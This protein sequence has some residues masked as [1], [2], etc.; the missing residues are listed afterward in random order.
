MAGFFDTLFGGGAEKEA[1]DKDR[2]LYGDFQ[3]KGADFLKTGYDTSTGYLNQAVGAYDP[4]K[5]LAGKYG[6]GTDT[7]LNALGVNGPAGS[8]AAQSAFQTTPGYALSNAAGLDA[9]NQRRAL[10]GGFNA[11]QTD[12][13]AI[14]FGQNNLYQTQYAPWMA[15]LQGVN[16]NNLAATTGAAAGTAGAYGSL[17]DLSKAYAGDQTSLLSNYTSGM[18]N[19][20]NLQAAGEAAGAKN[21]MSG[22][23][24]LGS[25]LLTGGGSAGFSGTAAGKLFGI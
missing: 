24:G 1:A 9:L 16:A 10:S 13:D 20:N 11:G 25:A 14:K 19:A 2:A 23:M 3:T 21:L 8:T 7:Y 4:L 18:T 15:G 5:A 12:M 6:Q 17:S 22:V